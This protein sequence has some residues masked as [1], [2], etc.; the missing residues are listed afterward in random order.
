MNANQV[1][2]YI[3]AKYPNAK[4]S[5]LAQIFL[6]VIANDEADRAIGFARLQ[7]ASDTQTCRNAVIHAE[8]CL[9]S[10]DGWE[11][12]SLGFNI[13]SSFP[14]LDSDDCDDIAEAVMRSRGLL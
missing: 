7:A 8:A 9:D 13:E 1:R 2:A 3:N 10:C 12:E 5:P 14:E 4:K 6:Q 11:V